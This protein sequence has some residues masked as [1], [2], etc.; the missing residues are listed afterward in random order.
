MESYTS[1]TG[2]RARL[3]IR[4]KLSEHA[5]L[6]PLQEIKD[7]FK[8]HRPKDGPKDRIKIG[9]VGAGMA[10]I[11]TAFILDKLAIPSLEYEILEGSRRVG[12][13]AYTHQFSDEK[14]DYYEAGA[15]RFPKISPMKRHVFFPMYIHTYSQLT[16]ANQ[17]L[18]LLRRHE[19]AAYPVLL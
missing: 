9:I 18:R 16:Y 19:D 12:G 17:V 5:D 11:Y 4:E 7:H 14:H 1:I 10:G 2:L 3:L 13:R 6:P 8:D 15:M